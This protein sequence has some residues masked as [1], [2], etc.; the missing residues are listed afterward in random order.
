M[1][2]V[3]FK[4]LE[5]TQPQRNLDVGSSDL[6]EQTGKIMAGLENLLMGEKLDMVLVQGDTNTAL[7]A[8]KLHSNEREMQFQNYGD[9]L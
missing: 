1:D 9:Y 7:A 3:F 5:L 6:G 4:L 8:A 2:R